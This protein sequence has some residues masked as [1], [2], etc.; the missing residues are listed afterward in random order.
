MSPRFTPITQQ[1]M[2]A[3][4]QADFKGF[5]FLNNKYK[6]FANT[7]NSEPDTKLK[8]VKESAADTTDL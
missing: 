4:N 6:C 7:P 1:S 8:D 5:S 2:S 3:V